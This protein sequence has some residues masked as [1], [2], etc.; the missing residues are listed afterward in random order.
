MHQMDSIKVEC[1][2]CNI[3]RY[4]EAD[5][6]GVQPGHCLTAGEIK[7]TDKV[8]L[9]TKP[10]DIIVTVNGRERDTELVDGPIAEA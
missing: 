7:F 10:G 9:V 3:P 8:S 5:V 6:T 4:I 1:L 2:P